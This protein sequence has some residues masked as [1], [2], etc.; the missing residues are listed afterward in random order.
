M[1]VF[2]LFKLGNFLKNRE[3]AEELRQQV[4]KTLA[5]GERVVLDFNKIVMMSRPFAEELVGELAAKSGIDIFRQ[6]VTLKNLSP[7]VETMLQSV[8][9]ARMQEDN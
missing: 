9:T 3:I 4:E 1:I 8:I 5:D 6:K 2:T 7:K